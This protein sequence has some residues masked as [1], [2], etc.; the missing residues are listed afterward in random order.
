ME[1]IKNETITF[2]RTVTY[3]TSYSFDDMKKQLS[4]KNYD[5]ERLLKIWEK[6]IDNEENDL[7][8]TDDQRE[9]GDGE[10]DDYF[11]EEVKD[12]DEQTEEDDEQTEDEKDT[13]VKIAT[14]CKKCDIWFG[15]DTT[16]DESL[17][18]MCR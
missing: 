6:M 9:D 7:Y 11:K 5:E 12:N 10:F 4:D 16:E 15:L 1:S 18:K 14:K 13:K 8:Y 3:A 2:R 17:C